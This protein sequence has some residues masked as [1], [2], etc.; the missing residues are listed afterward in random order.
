MEAFPPVYV[1]H[2]LPLV[3]LS[4]LGERSETLSGLDD[5]KQESGT[6]IVTSSRECRGDRADQL[7]EQFLRQ[8]GSQ[9]PWNAGALPGP[10]GLLLY[11]MKT[12]GRVGTVPS[13]QI[14]LEYIY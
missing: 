8:D 6:R 12:I 10:S 14:I 9:Q 2:N 4:G 5:V 11:R 7:L 13:E 1:E 3:I